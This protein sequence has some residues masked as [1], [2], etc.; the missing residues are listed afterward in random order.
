[1][2][3]AGVRLPPGFWWRAR[4][5]RYSP[6]AAQ[7]V[8]QMRHQP[9]AATAP[10]PPPGTGFRVRCRR[11]HVLSCHL[12]HHRAKRGRTAENGLPGTRLPGGGAV[13]AGWTASV[14][15]ALCSV[16]TQP[17]ISYQQVVGRRK[18]TEHL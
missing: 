12:P 7:P 13:I 10:R 15:C 6:L 9:P 5:F 3:D 1:M 14:L 18:S 8:Q 2:Q 11:W 17:C 16:D 4:S